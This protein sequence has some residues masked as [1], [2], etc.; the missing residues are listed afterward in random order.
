MDKAMETN[1]FLE[2]TSALNSKLNPEPRNMGRDYYKDPLPKS[3]EPCKPWT[4]L[5]P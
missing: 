3:Y 2:A 4:Y 5:F 1:I